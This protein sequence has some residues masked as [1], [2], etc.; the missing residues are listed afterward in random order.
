MKDNK[1]IALALSS[2]LVMT[3]CTG[4]DVDGTYEVPTGYA[5]II[6]PHTPAPVIPAS[7]PVVKPAPVAVAPVSAP[8][9]LPAIAPELVAPEPP[10]PAVAVTSQKQP[11]PTYTVAPPPAPAPVV[12]SRQNQPTPAKPAATV[13]PAPI[14]THAP[15]AAPA[16]VKVTYPDVSKQTYF[17][18][19]QPAKVTYPDVTRETYTRPADPTAPVR[20]KHPVMPGQNRG[21]RM[22]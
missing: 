12:S 2:T 6:R 3:A 19:Q 4:G 22:R 10:A 1:L 8:T 18:P 16:P 13:K 11:E 15:V 14:V 17:R 9:H 5:Q 7:A 21:L 20:K